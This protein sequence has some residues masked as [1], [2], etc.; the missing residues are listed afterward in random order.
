MNVAMIADAGDKDIK[1]QYLTEE[2]ARLKQCHIAT[3]NK[4]EV[5]KNIRRPT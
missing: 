1:I 4:T 2:N 3:V 5:E